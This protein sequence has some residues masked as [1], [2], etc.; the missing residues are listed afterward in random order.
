VIGLGDF[1]FQEGERCSLSVLRGGG[2]LL[3]QDRVVEKS[4][5]TGSREETEPG[6]DS[7]PLEGEEARVSVYN[8]VAEL[9][10]K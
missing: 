4:T 8:R 7:A 3:F 9:S 10:P 2:T 1:L 6:Q 5:K